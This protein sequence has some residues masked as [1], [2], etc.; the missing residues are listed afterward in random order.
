MEEDSLSSTWGGG[1][2]YSFVNEIRSLV[3]YACADLYVY[4]FAA[5]V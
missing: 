1:G 3:V 5:A 2:D 4:M